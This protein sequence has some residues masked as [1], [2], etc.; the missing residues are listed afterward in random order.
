M[1]KLEKYRPAAKNSSLILLS[2]IV[3][4]GVGIM[5]LVYAF[6][7]LSKAPDVNVYLFSCAGLALALLVH[8]FGFLRIANINISRILQTD[9]LKCLFS[10]FPLKSYLIVAIMVTLGTILR[11]SVI[12]KHFLSILYLG[13][14]LALILS[15][16]R[17]MRIFFREV[18]K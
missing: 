3:W 8:H 18:R 16:V 1:I 13:I 5:L 7:W 14:G 11:H 6:S 10:F 15:S 17:Y 12:P 4:I 9:E 2:G